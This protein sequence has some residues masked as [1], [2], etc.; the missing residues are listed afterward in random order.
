[1]IAIMHGNFK[2]AL[3]L[4]LLAFPLALFLAYR[5]TQKILIT[6][7]RKYPVIKTNKALIISFVLFI[8]LFGAT[9]LGLE[10]SGAIPKL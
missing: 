8:L 1:M 7:R 4:N 5:L 9:R 6:A 2:L 3:H 10:I